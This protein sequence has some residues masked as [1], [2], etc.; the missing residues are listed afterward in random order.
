[1]H[2]ND[3]TYNLLW[4]GHLLTGKVMWHGIC[5]GKANVS[6]TA[7]RAELIDINIK[8]DVPVPSHLPH[9]PLVNP[10]TRNFQG[11]GLGSELLTR[12][13]HELRIKGIQDVE[14]KMHGN[15]TRLRIWFKQMGFELGPQP[16]RFYMRI[17]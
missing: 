2:V 17:D 8:H 10:A 4:E 6:V 9:L 16:D 12:V 5:V 1:M 3:C 7:N 15:I 14:G 11:H 13:V